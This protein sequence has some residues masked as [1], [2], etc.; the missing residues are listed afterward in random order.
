MRSRLREV[1]GNHGMTDDM[2]AQ[3]GS[4]ERN[5]MIIYPDNHSTNDFY[6]EHRYSFSITKTLGVISEMHVVV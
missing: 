2:L 6:V 4:K 5:S 1:F 3:Y